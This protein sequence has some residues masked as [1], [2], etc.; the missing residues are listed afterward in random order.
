MSQ[1][2]FEVRY[3]HESD[4]VDAFACAKI[5]LRECRAHVREMRACNHTVTGQASTRKIFYDG[6]TGRRQ[7]DRT[8]VRRMYAKEKQEER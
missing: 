5:S 1:L 3:M 7:N 8:H 6:M 2:C 4:F